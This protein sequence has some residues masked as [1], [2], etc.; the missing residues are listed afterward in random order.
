MNISERLKNKSERCSILGQLPMCMHQ[1]ALAWDQ[2]ASKDSSQCESKGPE[3]TP[4]M[5]TFVSERARTGMTL[6]LLLLAT[7]RGADNAVPDLMLTL[8]ARADTIV[9]NACRCV[10]RYQCIHASQGQLAGTVLEIS[11]GSP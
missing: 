2:T 10:Q 3:S 11:C 9:T 8:D 6:A 5:T 7:G 1:L 4:P